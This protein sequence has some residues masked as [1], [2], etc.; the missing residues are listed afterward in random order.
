MTIT[1][2]CMKVFRPCTTLQLVLCADAH[3]L[4]AAADILLGYKVAV[5]LCEVHCN[6]G[7]AL[8]PSRNTSV[9]VTPPSTLLSCKLTRTLAN[10]DAYA[11]FASTS[12]NC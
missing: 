9:I 2:T 6:F 5:T 7:A 8:V 10:I 1:V 11:S 3:S 4:K 12:Q